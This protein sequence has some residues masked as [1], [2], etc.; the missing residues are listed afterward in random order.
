LRAHRILESGR[1]IAE[2]SDRSIHRHAMQ[3]R[4][5]RGLLLLGRVY[6]RRGWRT[7]AIERYEEA[8]EM[9]PAARG[10]RHMLDDL[11]ANVP[12]RAAGRQAASAIARIYGAEALPRIDA[13][14]ADPSLDDEAR[15]S[16]ERLRASIAAR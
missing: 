10:A 2:S 3:N 12:H 6:N 8:W 9:S 5:P 7:D 16:Y 4:D 14:L 13:L 11:L 15:A 1:S